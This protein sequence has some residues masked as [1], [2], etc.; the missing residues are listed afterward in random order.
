MAG[1][2]EFAFVHALVRD[3][4][5]GEL[6]RAARLARHRAAASWITERA[7]T[8]L[9]EDAEIVVAHL[10]QALAL[11]IATGAADEVPE[12][13]AGLVDALLAAADTAMRTE[14]PRAIAN[15]RR[16][17]DLAPADGAGRPNALASLG[18]AL[19]ATSE[20]PAASEILREAAETLRARGDEV[21]A[22][23]LG[24]PLADALFQVGHADTA[25]ATLAVARA[26]LEGHPG[27]GLVSVISAQASLRSNGEHA[28]ALDLAGEAIILAA[29]LGLPP[30]PRALGTRGYAQQM[31]DQGAAELDLRAAIDGAVTAGDLRTAYGAYTNL[32]VMRA[33]FQGPEPSLAVFDEAIAFAQA[34][35]LAAE[36]ARAVRTQ[37][38]WMAGRW[39]ELLSEAEDVSA[40]ALQHGDL[41]AAAV[42]HWTAACVR[43]DRGEPITSTD[44]L[45][46]MARD[47]GAPPTWVAP[48]VAEA[49]VARG[50]TEGA[51]RALAAA[52]DATPG[53]ELWNLSRFVLACLRVR[54][55]DLARRAFATGAS[56]KETATER[57]VGRA[58][59][60]EID[61]D[62]A[63]ARI[64]YH[65][66]AATSHSVG[67]QPEEAVALAGLGRCLLALGETGEGVARLRESRV[68]WERLRATPRIA[69]IDALLAS[70]GAAPSPGPE[71]S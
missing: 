21:A 48:V 68:I 51:R 13:R 43:L 41:P 20:Y 62:A 10:E 22:A 45:E 12:I 60:A 57:Q 66:A 3:V 16:A 38:L 63:A 29:S 35:G 26:V 44:S 67:S 32:A 14:V 71:S 42:V 9:G 18:R 27:P 25:E 33:D 17:L 70:V 59:L 56:R 58:I 34:H 15:L 7:G 28:D 11:A 36:R 30:P 49:A 8:S 6:P 55:P 24:A 47:I 64:G 23:E 5:Y 50:D 52:L 40:L 53:G 46:S 4:S 65:E 61:L 37:A 2:A 19:L 31:T 54:A 1:E 69:E 39:D